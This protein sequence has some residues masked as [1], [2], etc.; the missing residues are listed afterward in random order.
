LSGDLTTLAVAAATIG[1][2]HALLGPDHYLPFIAMSRARRW[3][4]LKT[5]LG[6]L[7]CG[8]GHVGSSVALGLVG[9][10]LGLAA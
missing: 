4:L 6:T 9:I 3:S 10:A 8:L 1:L 5:S 7:L 2:P